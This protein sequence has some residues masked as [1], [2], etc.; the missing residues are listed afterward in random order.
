[1]IL[2][3]RVGAPQSMLAVSSTQLLELNW[4]VALKKSEAHGAAE[5]SL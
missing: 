3:A 2:K 5:K 4:K 1:M